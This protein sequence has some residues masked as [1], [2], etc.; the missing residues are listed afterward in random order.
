MKEI[1][2]MNQTKVAYKLQKILGEKYTVLFDDCES[3]LTRVFYNA[4]NNKKYL[5]KE[6]PN[7][8]MRSSISINDFTISSELASMLLAT[9]NL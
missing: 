3:G 9:N 2:R 8:E 4:K 6:V 7:E 1:K 5:I